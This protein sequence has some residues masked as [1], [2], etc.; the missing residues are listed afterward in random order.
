[1]ESSEQFERDMKLVDA[2]MTLASFGTSRHDARRGIEWKLSFGLWALMAGATVRGFAALPILMAVVP[3]IYAWWIRNIWLRHSADVELTWNFVNE[4]QRLL[5]IHDIRTIP[6]KPELRI[7]RGR[8]LTGRHSWFGFLGDW[9]LGF[10]VLVTV[11]LTIGAFATAD[12]V[13]V[14]QL[15]LRSGPT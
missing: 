14:Y 10:Q 12:R 8:P 1:M 6:P 11:M 4:A 9:A 3:V 15:M 13:T 7:G 2:C 5:G